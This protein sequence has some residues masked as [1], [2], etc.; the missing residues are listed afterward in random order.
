M[1][2]VPRIL[3]FDS[4]VGA[5]S[6]LAELRAALPAARFIYASDNAAYPYGTRS[7]TDVTE[8]VATVLEALHA[9]F[10]PDLIVVGCNTASTVALPRLRT[11]LTMPVVGVV[12]AIKPAAALTRTG[13]LALLATP[14]TV[15]RSYTQQLIDEFAG[16]CEV[17]R[18]GSS[19][20]VALAECK[21]RGAVIETGEIARIL[22]PLH[23]PPRGTRIDTIVLGCTHFPLLADELRIAFGRPVHWIDSAAA[24]ARRA[25]SLLADDHHHSNAGQT[26]ER[27]TDLAVFTKQPE[28]GLLPALT[29][30][31]FKRVEIIPC[32]PARLV[33]SETSDTGQQ[34]RPA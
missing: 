10:T 6:L 28:P 31:G 23:A 13:C 20:L 34:T 25:A 8:R 15:C 14:G 12:P 11:R 17:V 16:G 29:R 27:G 7:E 24:I 1:T 18:L 21:L 26:G 33:T 22:A 5:L 2:V 19:E 30:Y 9:Q 4:G 3:L 32:E